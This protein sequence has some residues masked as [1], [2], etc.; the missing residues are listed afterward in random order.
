[1]PHLCMAMWIAGLVAASPDRLKGM[2]FIWKATP[3]PNRFNQA[4]ERPLPL[5]QPT[6]PGGAFKVGSAAGRQPDREGRAPAVRALSSG[7]PFRV[8]CP[9]RPTPT[10]HLHRRSARRPPLTV[11]QQGVRRLER[12]DRQALRRIARQVEVNSPCAVALPDHSH[13]LLENN[14]ESHRNVP[15][16]QRGQHQFPPRPLAAREAIH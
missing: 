11:P 14:A 13:R 9:G 1:M 15:V 16:S 2:G 6:A 3:L 8:R 7:R 12:I 5:G 4:L 10:R